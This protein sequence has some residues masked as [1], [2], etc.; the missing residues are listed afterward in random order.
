MDEPA[1]ISF[2]TRKRLLLYAWG[3]ALV[4]HAI[5]ILPQVELAIFLPALPEGI[6]LLLFPFQAFGNLSSHAMTLLTGFLLVAGWLL[7][8]GPTIGALVTRKRTLYFVFYAFLCLMLILNAV[9]C[10]QQASGI[11]GLRNH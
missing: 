6:I 2:E 11:N 5:A 4:I 1:D 9:G 3:V 7:F 8:L 10:H